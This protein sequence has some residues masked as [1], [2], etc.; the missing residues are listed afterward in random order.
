MRL[1]ARSLHHLVQAQA[2]GNSIV[3][4]SPGFIQV[5]LLQ[6]GKDVDNV[7]SQHPTGPGVSR[8]LVRLTTSRDLYF[9]SQACQNRE[10]QCMA[11]FGRSLKILKQNH[12]FATVCS[13]RVVILSVLA[14]NLLYV[15]HKA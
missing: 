14:G 2:Y 7:V 11:S 8:L 3:K 10:D 15:F 4:I 6:L 12:A 5:V 9:M 13:L 1:P